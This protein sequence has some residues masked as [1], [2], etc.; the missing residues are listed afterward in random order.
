MISTP[1]AFNW[2]TPLYSNYLSSISPGIVPLALPGKKKTAFW[3]EAVCTLLDSRS[4]FL[5]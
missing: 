4:V 2:E 3:I 1:I 5:R